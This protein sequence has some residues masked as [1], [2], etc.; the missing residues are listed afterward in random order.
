MAKTGRVTVTVRNDNGAPALSKRQRK[1]NKNAKKALAAG[2]ANSGDNGENAAAEGGANNDD[3]ER[4][5]GADNEH[6]EAGEF[7]E[8]D[9]RGSPARDESAP[10]GTNPP[11]QA[12]VPEDGETT[13]SAPRTP[14]TD[15]H[16]S[17]HT[18]FEEA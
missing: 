14:H 4:E 3:S 9:E 10:S 7:V 5:E 8:N 15:F 1:R 6:S 16:V 12:H 13:N 18:I 2:A 17:P 11:Q